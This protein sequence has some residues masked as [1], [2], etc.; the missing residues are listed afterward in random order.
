MTYPLAFYER[1]LRRG[2]LQQYRKRALK[3]FGLRPIDL[4]GWRGKWITFCKFA[5]QR[6]SI[7]ELHFPLYVLK[8]SEA[9]LRR[10]SQIGRARDQYQLGRIGDTGGYTRNSC[11]FI[12]AFQNQQERKVNG[13]TARAVEKAARVRRGQTKEKHAHIA[14]M[15]EKLAGRTMQEHAYLAE[16]GLKRGRAYRVISPTGKTYTG[17]SLNA[18]CKSAG[19]NQSAMSLLCRGKIETYKGWKGEYTED[20][21]PWYQ[22]KKTKERSRRAVT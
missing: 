5:E 16:A 10:P 17:Q 1:G 9:G 20:L 7:N 22:T 13:G 12:T 15:A 14:A 19:L 18:L 11:R 4:K 2:E 21:K 6:T 3:A 8:A